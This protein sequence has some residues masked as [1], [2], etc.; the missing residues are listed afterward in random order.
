M[1][2]EPSPG[3]HGAPRLVRFRAMSPGDLPAVAAVERASYPFPWSEGIFRDCLRVGYLCRVADLD[4]EIV[5]YGVLAMGAGEAH[6]LNL[7]VDQHWRRYGIG[8]LLLAELISRARNAGVHRMLLEV[9][10]SN[11]VA[12]RLYQKYGFRPIGSRRGYYRADRGREDAMVLAL[13]L[14]PGD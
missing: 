1:S 3:P 12:L 7:C 2:A 13:R 8:E 9:R 11:E 10:P 4:R 5:A 6:L 14:L